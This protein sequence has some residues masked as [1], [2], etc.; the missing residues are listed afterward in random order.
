MYDNTSKIAIN[1]IIL[2]SLSQETKK[3]YFKYMYEYDTPESP[4]LGHLK[5]CILKSIR[6]S[7]M[8]NHEIINCK[9]DIFL[10]ILF[11]TFL[12]KDKRR[13]TILFFLKSFYN[14]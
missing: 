5:H 7:K 4:N 14:Q 1:Q 3:Y 2:L 6:R 11:R 13:A 8:K 10:N 9:S 12:S